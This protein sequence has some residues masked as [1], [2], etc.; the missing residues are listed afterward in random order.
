[1]KKEKDIKDEGFGSGISP[2][3]A[4]GCSFQ[5]KPSC[6]VAVIRLIDLAPELM[7]T[8]LHSACSDDCDTQPECSEADRGGEENQTDDKFSR[9]SQS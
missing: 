2:L 7:F 6:V 1:M 9:F 5:H 8:L 3:S 4:S